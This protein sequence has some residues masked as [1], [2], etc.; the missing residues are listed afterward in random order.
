MVRFQDCRLLRQ[1]LLSRC[2][3]F[4]TL[5]CSIASQSG[6][7][8]PDLLAQRSSSQLGSYCHASTCRT[9]STLSR[10]CSK[11]VISP[12]ETLRAVEI[13]RLRLRDLKPI[14]P[15]NDADRP[16][17]EECFTAA[18]AVDA[19]A[20]VSAA[21]LTGEHDG[22]QEYVE[23]YRDPWYRRRSRR[24]MSALPPAASALSA[25]SADEPYS[26][27]SDEDE[28]E[29]VELKADDAATQAQLDRLIDIL[30]TPVQPAYSQQ[31]GLEDSDDTLHNPKDEASTDGAGAETLNGQDDGAEDAA[32]R[33]IHAKRAQTASSMQ[34]GIPRSR[35]W[36]DAVN[37]A[38]PGARR[39]TSN[40]LRVDRRPGFEYQGAEP[41]AAECEVGW[42][43]G[44]AAQPDITIAEAV[45]AVQSWAAQPAE[46]RQDTSHSK[47]E[48]AIAEPRNESAAEPGQP[49][50][51]QP[52]QRQPSG[53]AAA[54]AAVTDQQLFDQ[55]FGMSGAPAAPPSAAAEASS[56]PQ[57]RSFL[58]LEDTDA[59]GS[60]VRLS[61]RWD[62]DRETA[63]GVVTWLP[64]WAQVPFIPVTSP[65]TFFMLSTLSIVVAMPFDTFLQNTT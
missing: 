42:D 41:A 63:D 48:L 33:Q 24:S 55:A 60:S 50:Q 44:R 51:G 1:T 6:G 56:A 13:L 52:G 14:I 5:V 4:E 9:F 47:P 28:D 59:G 22:H 45:S 3:R 10:S 26:Y 31:T 57:A 7:F 64:P 21:G 35:S 23:P 18:T 37:L 36:P 8:Q 11:E 54:A 29:Y 12:Q 61:I 20:E 2:L 40:A 49:G 27:T 65:P 62:A 46:T 32:D 16:G 17:V 53:A 38:G 43:G 19:E 25:S 30:Y 39:Y 15:V 58:S 34:K